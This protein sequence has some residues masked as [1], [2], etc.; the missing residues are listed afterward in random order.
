MGAFEI[1]LFEG[2]EDGKGTDDE[3]LVD[4]AMWGGGP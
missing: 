4:G 1:A 3:E 2:D